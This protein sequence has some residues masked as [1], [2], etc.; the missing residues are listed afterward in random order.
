[1]P[2]RKPAYSQLFLQ[3]LLFSIAML[4][5]HSC[6]VLDIVLGSTYAP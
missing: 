6:T 2:R 4:N 3:V 1:M 5:Q